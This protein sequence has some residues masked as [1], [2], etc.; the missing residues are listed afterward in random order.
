MTETG[1]LCLCVI[2]TYVPT[3]PFL[4]S[5]TRTIFW[6]SAFLCRHTAGEQRFAHAQQHVHMAWG[7][8][9]VHVLLLLNGSSGAHCLLD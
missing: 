4:Y 3:A 7:G 5:E 8:Q 9:G 6:C 1:R 2:V